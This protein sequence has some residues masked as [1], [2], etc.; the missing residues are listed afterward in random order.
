MLIFTF[1]TLPY[2]TEFLNSESL[3]KNIKRQKRWRLP[4]CDDSESLFYCPNFES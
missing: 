2:K 4:L 1:H 3:R